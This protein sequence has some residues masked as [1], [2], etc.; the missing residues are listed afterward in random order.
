MRRN[1]TDAQIFSLSRFAED[2]CERSSR[3][4]EELQQELREARLE[5]QHREEYEQVARLI[6]SMPS[7][8]EIRR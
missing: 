4:L 2:E 6:N 5:R 3:R 8:D 7:R 1:E